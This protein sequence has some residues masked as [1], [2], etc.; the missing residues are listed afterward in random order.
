MDLKEIH[1][2]FQLG[3][4]IFVMDLRKN[5]S[6]KDA[7]RNLFM[8]EKNKIEC[9]RAIVEALNALLATKD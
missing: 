7:K 5:K 8:E 1:N 4:S 2:C 6:K 9:L 3:S